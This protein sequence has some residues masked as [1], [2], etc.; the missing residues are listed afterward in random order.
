VLLQGICVAKAVVVAFGA[1][2]PAAAAAAAAAQE[3]EVG[4]TMCA[5][6]RPDGQHM[7]NL[8]ITSN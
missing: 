1:W 8:V 2:Y 7:L 6:K 4:V 5:G 3:I